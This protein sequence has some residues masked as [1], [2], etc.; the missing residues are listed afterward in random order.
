MQVKRHYSKA[1]ITEAVIDLRVTLP[2]GFSVNKLAE[3]HPH[4]SHLAIISRQ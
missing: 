3:I 4:I 1:P 2:E